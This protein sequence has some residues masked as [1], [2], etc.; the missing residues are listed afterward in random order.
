[1]SLP[2]LLLV[3]DSEAILAFERAALGGHYVCTT[4][5][6]GIEAIEKARQISPDAILLDL[7][8]PEMDGDEVLARLKLDDSLATIPVIIISS[9]RARAEACL[10]QGAAAFL[11]KP[12]RADELLALVGRVLD[13]AQRAKQRGNLTVITLKAGT[14]ELAVPLSAVRTVLPQIATSPLAVG[15]SYLNEMFEIDGQPVFVLDLPKRLGVQHSEPL[16]ERKLVIIEHDRLQLALCVDGVRDPEEFEAS[17]VTPTKELGG[18]EHGLL[19]EALIGVARTSRGPR[20]VVN[21]SAF[22]SRELLRRLRS[23]QSV[24]A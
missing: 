1:M 8:M 15:P 20:P 3:D 11:P 17:D 13:E 7:S 6:N 18:T 16:I 12:I 2:N 14:L 23:L 24:A 19:A 21:P 5:V 10:S 22:L 9:E 4:A